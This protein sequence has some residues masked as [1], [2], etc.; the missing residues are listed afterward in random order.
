MM[1]NVSDRDIWTRNKLDILIALNLAW[2]DLTFLH[3]LFQSRKQ[4]E[5]LTRLNLTPT[6]PSQ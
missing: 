2:V 3:R 6:T 1:T 5:C 4:L